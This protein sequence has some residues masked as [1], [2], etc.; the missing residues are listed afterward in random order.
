MDPDGT[1]N[2]GDIDIGTSNACQLMGIYDI[3]SYFTNNTHDADTRSA[4]QREI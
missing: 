2:M 4:K 1:Y 3:E